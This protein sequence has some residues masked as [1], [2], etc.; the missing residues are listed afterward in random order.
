MKL[1]V[2]LSI[3]LGLLLLLLAL[4]GCDT[5]GYY[6]KTGTPGPIPSRGGVVCALA[7]KRSFAIVDTSQQCAQLGGVLLRPALAR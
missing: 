4:S 7:G 6:V 3:V 2:F 5:N 1:S